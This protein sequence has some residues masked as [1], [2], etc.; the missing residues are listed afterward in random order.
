VTGF[1]ATEVFVRGQ[2]GVIL[3][4]NGST[5][6]AEGTGVTEF[7]QDLIA[8]PGN[9]LIALTSNARNSRRRSPAGVW[10][11]AGWGPGGSLSFQR[12]W[13]NAENNVY[14]TRYSGSGTYLWQWNGTAWSEVSILS[15]YLDDVAGNLAGDITAVG[16]VGRIW[17]FGRRP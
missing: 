1:S 16:N 12:G 14:A 13:G 15:D 8:L 6:A 7:V 4:F 9:V 3:R 2:G 5:W 17:R 10:S 11:S